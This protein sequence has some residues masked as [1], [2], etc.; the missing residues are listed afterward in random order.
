M[1]KFFKEPLVQFIVAGAVLFL[2]T[3][4]FSQNQTGNTSAY[5][6]TVNDET[7]M[8]YLQSQAKSFGT[9]GVRQYFTNLPDHEKKTLTD[10]F[11]RDEALFREALALGLDDNDEVIRRRLIQKMEYIAQGFYNELP[12]LNEADLTVYF[13]QHQESYRIAASVSFTHVFF[14]A[15]K[16]GGA[17]ACLKLAKQQLAKLNK[18]QVPFEDASRFGDRF[19]YS[20]N[21][22][23]RTRD[24]ISSH[25]GEDFQQVVS[26]LRAGDKWQGPLHSDYGIHLVLLKKTTPSRLPKLSEVAHAVLSDAQRDQ[27]QAMKRD[28]ITEL[29]NKYTIRGISDSP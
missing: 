2:I 28:A 27:R 29:V 9:E 19:I 5:E 11:I 17:K 20:R 1:K 7:L 12:E 26:K 10:D 3:H 25:F 4:Y 6:I 8:Q 23:E 24:F 21:Y 18:N 22:I 15:K 16:H 13:Q 14:S